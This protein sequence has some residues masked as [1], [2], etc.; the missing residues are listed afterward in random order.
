MTEQRKLII[1]V[2]V[3]WFFLSHRLPIALAAQKAGYKV[4]IVTKD[5][6]KFKEIEEL[7]LNPINLPVERS[8]KNFIREFSIIKELKKI[9]AEIQP[10]VVHNVTLKISIYSSLAAKRFPTIKVINAIS[11]LGYNFTG[12]RR[13]ITRILIFTLMQRAFKGGGRH[14]I[15]QNPDDLDVF[16]DLKLADKNSCTL[17]KGSGI[18]LA[19][20]SEQK[21]PNEDKIKFILTARMLKDKGV[22]EYIDAA[23]IVEKNCPGRAEWTMAGGIDLDNPAALTEAELN[24]LIKDSQIQWLGYRSDIKDLLSLSHIVVLP[25]YREGLPKSLI[26]ACAIGRPIITTDSVGCRECVDDGK[27]GFLVPIGDANTLAEKMMYFLNNQ[28]QMKVMGK[29]SREK[30]VKEFSIEK[31]INETLALYE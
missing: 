9:F 31:V 11:G 25:S 24:G 18:D 4:F 29:E 8:G 28:D 22:V 5:T 3:D 14:F 10:Q 21:F 20:F 12:K 27:N 26:E 2:N 23:K 6:G 13:S 7:G 1:V 19:E 16:L 17:I 30:A 15:F